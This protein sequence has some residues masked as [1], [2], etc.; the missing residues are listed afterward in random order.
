MVKCRNEKT[1]LCTVGVAALLL[2]LPAATQACSCNLPPLKKSEKQLIELGRKAS[3]A[4]FV[5]E[6]VE[7]SVPTITSGESTWVSEVKFK[8]RKWWKGAGAEEVSVFTANVCCICGYEFKVGESYLV[9][10]HGE[11]RLS[12]DTCTRT[13]KLAEAEDDL[14]VLGVGTAIKNVRRE[15][16]PSDARNLTTRW[17][18]RV[19]RLLF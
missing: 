14:K 1:I 19:N 4:V 13:R 2:L 11:N 17:T 7:I 5:G 9:Y 8:V 3:K 6:V 16:L 15:S 12:T 10:A 18:G